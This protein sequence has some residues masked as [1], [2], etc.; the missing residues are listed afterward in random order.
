MR[1]QEI[2]S[3]AQRIHLHPQ[4][5]ESMRE[6]GLNPDD[7]GFKGYLEGFR[8]GCFPHGGGGFGLN[9]ILQ[10]FLG[11]DDIREATLFPRDPGRLAP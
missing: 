7:E 6:K 3:G 10:Y 11:L 4:L 2:M 8:L 5:C 9:R 1:G